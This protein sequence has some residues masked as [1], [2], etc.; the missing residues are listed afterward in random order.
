MDI[1]TPPTLVPP[2]PP[3]PDQ[4]P[5][6]PFRLSSST[7]PPPPP[8]SRDAASQPTPQAP[9]KVVSSRRFPTKALFLALAGLLVVGLGAFAALFLLKSSPLSSQTIKYWGL[10]EP[11]TVMKPLIEE[12]QAS[13]P[14]VKIEYTQQSPT[15]YRERLQAALSQ[16]KGP[17]I[18][19]IHNSWIPMFRADLA[20]VPPEIYSPQ[21]YDST[22]YPTARADLRL[23]S[24]YLAIPLEYD[25]LAMYINDDLLRGS[26]HSVPQNW[27]DFRVAAQ[28]MTRCDTPDS[29]CTSKSRPII[30]GAA[31]GTADNIDHWQ[32][33]LSVIMLQNKVNLNSPSGKAAEDVLTYYTNFA[34]FD[35][36]WNSTL[37]SS[38]TQFAAGK[39]GFYFAPSWRVFE[40]QSKNP[41]L[42][43]SLH[44]IPQLPVDTSRGEQ[45][46]AW[47]SYWVEAVN[48]KSPQQGTAW[49]FIKFLSSKDGQQKFFQ[50]STSS[51]RAF[52]EPYSRVDLASSVQGS[53]YLGAIISQ[54]PIS[55]SWYIASHTFDGSSG[56]N[57][58]LSTYFADAVNYVVN[59]GSPGSAIKTL[60]NGI[61]QVLTQY[62]LIVAPPTQK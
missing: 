36:M 21:E 17:D 32:D 61:S 31:M 39:V 40:I 51:G 56:I 19:R 41:N 16:S 26:G 13:H 5:N 43:F 54:A 49:D 58:R 25:G 55:H 7:P 27:D 44:P 10:W 2:A 59:G 15:E 60:N 45:P 48:K 28:A 6:L 42:K 22:F 53:P 52:G 46:I 11:D 20:P 14:K 18:F 1:T 8:P 38:T 37:P 12:Y 30:S 57:S 34:K 9:V 4:S 50:Q 24:S 23:G 33:I 35:R 47:A 29:S 3:P 62:G